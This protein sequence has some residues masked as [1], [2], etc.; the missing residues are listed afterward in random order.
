M[1]PMPARY[2]QALIAASR[3]DHRF[4]GSA[5]A[6]AGRLG[7]L[8]AARP[9]P[10]WRGALTCRPEDV[11]A[12]LP[13]LVPHRLIPGGGISTRLMTGQRASWLEVV[14]TVGCEFTFAPQVRSRRTRCGRIHTCGTNQRGDEHEP[15]PDFDSLVPALPYDRR[16]FW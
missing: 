16:G 2:L 3:S 7:F 10:I 15:K 14:I 13:A 12:V 9:G 4:P 6:A 11:Q 5:C 8:R 1:S